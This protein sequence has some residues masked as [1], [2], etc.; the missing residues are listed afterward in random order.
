MTRLDSDPEV[1]APVRRRRRIGTLEVF[2]AGLVVL[3]L[4][5][6]WIAEAFSSA[7]IANFATV[8]VSIC[9]QAFP[10]LVLGVIVS[11]AIAAFVPPSFFTRFLPSKPAAAVPVAEV[12]VLMSVPSKELTLTV[13]ATGAPIGTSAPTSTVTGTL[14]AYPINGCST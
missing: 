9:V 14:T 7:A 11:G 6:R 10:F 12:L 3:I 4:G 13:N 1:A 5:Q 8:F 2:T